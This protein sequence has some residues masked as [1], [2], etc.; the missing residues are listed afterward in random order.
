[1][2][3]V[4]HLVQR[5]LY[6]FDR[7]SSDL[8]IRGSTALRA[9]ECYNNVVSYIYEHLIILGVMSESDSRANDICHRFPGTF[10]LSFCSVRV[11]LNDA[12]K[13]AVVA[14]YTQKQIPRRCRTVL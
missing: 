10:W 11:C 14:S 12:L 6:E 1:M 7:W 9:W 8:D 2:G 13:E 5:E 4:V 3:T